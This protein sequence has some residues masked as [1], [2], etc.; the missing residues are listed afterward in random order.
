MLSERNEAVV[1]LETEV[2]TLKDRISKLEERIQCNDSYER[3]DTLVF[4]DSTIPTP[5]NSE[6]CTQLV[7]G[8]IQEHLQVLL[9]QTEVSVCHT[10]LSRSN[11][12][13]LH[14]Q[15]VII[16]FCRRSKKVDLLSSASKKKV[17]IFFIN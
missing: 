5:S 6:N 1:K 16:K 10:L 4:P 12:D 13:T 15:N 11:S 17:H 8:L 9:Q 2:V 7:T 3:R 14:K